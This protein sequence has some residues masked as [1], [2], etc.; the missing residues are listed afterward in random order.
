MAGKALV[1][2][3]SAIL[4]TPADSLNHL[5]SA[6]T[7]LSFLAE[8]FRRT[9]LYDSLLLSGNFTILAPVN[10]AFINAGYDSVGAIDSA[11][12][13]SLVR[14]AEYHTVNGLFFS[15]TLAGMNSLPT[16]EGGMV[17]VSV[18][19]G[20]LYFTGNSS[21]PQAGLVRGNQLA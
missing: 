5:L 2:R 11:D 10:S 8:V 7:S 19:N 18:Q 15:N 1:Y 20:F 4:K 9:N 21:P 17:A 16:L 3:L 14:L 6:D 12:L 13:G